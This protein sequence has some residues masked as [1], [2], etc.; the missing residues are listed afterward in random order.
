MTAQP[1]GRLKSGY[2]SRATIRQFA[3]VA[4]EL[5]IDPGGLEVNADGMIRVLDRQAL[6]AAP[7]DEFAKWEAGGKL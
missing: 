6:A 3:G 4:R 1:K 2:P 7:Q 5:G